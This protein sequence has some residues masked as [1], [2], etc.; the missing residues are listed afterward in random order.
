MQG[1]SHPT[2][3]SVARRL[4]AATCTAWYVAL[5]LGVELPADLPS[6]AESACGRACGCGPRQT[7]PDCCCR[8]PSTTLATRQQRR[9]CC[10]HRLPQPSGQLAGRSCCQPERP[11][12]SRPRQQTLRLI[13]AL[14]CRGHQSGWL[15]L[16]GLAL[17]PDAACCGPLASPVESHAALDLRFESF[18][19]D[20]PTPPPRSLP[21]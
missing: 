2:R 7:G 8:G 21:G 5:A 12:A 19:E 13:D 9:A 4:V 10:S 11:S 18:A 14:S 16:D 17:P 20:P 3:H 15:S 1:R 6:A